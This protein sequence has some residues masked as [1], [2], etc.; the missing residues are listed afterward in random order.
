MEREVINEYFHE[1]DEAMKRGDYDEAK[2]NLQ[3]L[4]L[5][6]R[7]M[8]G[9]H[10]KWIQDEI[11]SCRSQFTR[12]QLLSKDHPSDRVATPKTILDLL[13]ES[14][15]KLAES[16]EVAADTLQHLQD[17]RQ[18]LERAKTNLKDTSDDLNTSNKFL[19]R[20]SS[21]WRN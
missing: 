4:E 20:M 1:F 10:K 3:L 8:E 21:F 19:N 9:D 18:K 12:Q 14:R 11:I 6:T 2:T 17:Q 5:H 15:Q 7:H 16:E 13:I